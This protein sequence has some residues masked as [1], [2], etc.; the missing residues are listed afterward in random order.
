MTSLRLLAP[1]KLNFFLHITG[2][3]VDGYHLIESLAGFT[4]FGDMVEF[5]DASELSLALDG[6]FASSLKADNDNLVLRA[7]R[8]LQLHCGQARGAR[9]VL[10][11]HIPM[12]AGLGGGSSDAAAA[13]KGLA[14]L[15][16][17]SIPEAELQRLALPLGSDVPV[18]LQQKT[19]W[20]SG[21]G[22][23]VRPVDIKIA[24]WIL[25]LNPAIALLTADVYRRFSAPFRPASAPLPSLS[26]FDALVAAMQLRHNDLEAPAIA[27]L[28]VI[29]EQLSLLRSTDGCKIARMSGSGA[30][31]YAL[32]D[33]KQQAELAAHTIQSKQPSWWVQ[34]T[35]FLR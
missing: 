29:A 34:L 28:P 19:A 16:Q 32:Y 30:T 8:A 31:C 3:R 6:P 7:A 26:G 4:E 2:K 15:W 11:K 22:E 27:L 13:L 12:G 25:L 10:H 35:T 18:C 21:I 23:Y 14:Q 33:N 5:S 20:V 17:L 1:A 9:I 24:G